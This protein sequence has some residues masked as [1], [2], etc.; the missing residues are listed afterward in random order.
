MSKAQIQE[1]NLQRMKGE[2]MKTTSI[3]LVGL[4]LLIVPFTAFGVRTQST[5]ED[6]AVRQTVEYYLYGLKHNNVESLKKAF[7]P[8][9]KLFFVKRDNQLGQLTQEQWYQGFAAS[10]GKEE[11]GDLRINSVE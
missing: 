9:A 4:L 1:G 7:Y 3:G 11:K 10:A 6:A 2:R 8:E 5:T